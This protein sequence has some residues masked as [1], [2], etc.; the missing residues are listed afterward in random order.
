MAK[1]SKERFIM[2]MDALWFVSGA[3]RSPMSTD[4]VEVFVSMGENGEERLFL[5]RDEHCTEVL[6]GAGPFGRTLYRKEANKGLAEKVG[7][8]QKRWTGNRVRW[9]YV[10]VMDNSDL[11]KKSN[12]ALLEEQLELLERMDAER[13]SGNVSMSSIERYDAVTEELATRSVSLYDQL[14]AK[15]LNVNEACVVELCAKGL[16][17]KEIAAQMD[18]TEKTVKKY[19][20]FAYAALDLDSRA[21]LIVWCLPYMSNR[22]VY[23]ASGTIQTKS[24]GYSIDLCIPFEVEVIYDGEDNKISGVQVDSSQVDNYDY[25]KLMS[26]ISYGYESEPAYTNAFW[27][28]IKE[29]AK[30]RAI[31]AT[32]HDQG[33]LSTTVNR[34]KN[35]KVSVFE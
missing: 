30:Q 6:V 13:S 25:N 33:K 34:P 14:C 21:Q 23:R 7:E 11:A 22:A 16:S 12:A 24:L 18:I 8:L 29:V 10:P 3:P 15:G 26:A 17:N 35:V 5:T 4:T 31:D 9:A 2:L 1:I 27:D 28:H 20:K 32:L 19:L